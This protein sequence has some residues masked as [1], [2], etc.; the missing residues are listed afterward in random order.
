VR[1]FKG[2]ASTGVR[3][4]KLLGEDYVVSMSILHHVDVTTAEA[5]A[6][7]K[8]AAAIRRAAGDDDG[9]EG[10]EA[11]ELEEA[12]LS[13]DRYSSLGAEEEFILTITENGFGKRSSAYDYR[14]S[15]RGGQG[16]AAMDM[17][18]RKGKLL[19]SFPVE[20]HDDI[21]LVTDKGK[22]IR[23]PVDGISVRRRS[24]QG[25]TV[26]AT[27]KDEKVVSVERIDESS[28]GEDGDEESETE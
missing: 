12:A 20:D 14:T 22:L 3:G 8:Q 21:M 25:V 28:S 2:R 19:A 17:T 24:T 10:A 9:E 7:L 4:I 5:Q 26:F 27:A 13:Q 6:Y 11:D 23:V 15:G 1:V 16:I 18:A